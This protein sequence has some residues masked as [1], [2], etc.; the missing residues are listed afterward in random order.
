MTYSRDDYIRAG[1]EPVEKLSMK[2]WVELQGVREA[3][4]VWSGRI[5]KWRADH[6]GDEKL[7]P[8][9]S[10]ILGT[11][12]S[13]PTTPVSQGKKCPLAALVGVKTF[14]GNCA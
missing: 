9:S 6:E 13:R 12:E 3:V 4:G 11:R 10:M 5:E 8:S 1:I 7:S 2:E 14:G